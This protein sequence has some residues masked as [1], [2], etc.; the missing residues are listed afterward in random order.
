MK[1][2]LRFTIF[3]LAFSL[4]TFLFAHEFWLM[5]TNFFPKIGEVVRM[6]VRIGENFEGERWGGGMRRIEQLK[7]RTTDKWLDVP[8][9]Q[10]DSAVQPPLIN[11]EKEGT[12]V[13]T[14]ATNSS[15]IELEPVKFEEYLK[16]DGL[17]NALDYRKS[18]GETQKN[19]R[20]L[21]RRCAKTLLQVGA[22]KT[23]VATQATDLILDIKP[24]INPYTL[25]SKQA[26]SCRF[27]YE[28]APMVNAL[29][30]CWRRVNNKTEIEF[31]QTDSQGNATFDLVKK[32]KGAYMVS[33]VKMVRLT[34]NP[35]ADWQSTWGSM[36]FAIQ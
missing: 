1:Y 13:L 36:T 24:A 6:D 21:Y 8:V 11:I 3:V 23:D 32:G 28:D 20:E 26:L 22:I 25:S 30:R 16:E 35:K 12:H 34:N 10:T 4:T 17:I 14:L 18:N 33:T 15:F 31:K 5:P 27:R 2:I 19:G 9:Q 7:I 29:V